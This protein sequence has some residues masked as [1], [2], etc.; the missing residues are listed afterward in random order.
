VSPP[1]RSTGPAAAPCRLCGAETE[2]AL[3]VTD[4]NRGLG[5]DRFEYRLCRSCGVTSMPSVPENLADYY[6]SDGYGSVGDVEVPRLVEG[7]RQKLELLAS[8]AP[9][10][11]MIEI[12][13]G[14]GMFTR[15]AQRS[16]F[17]VTAIEMDD[18]YCR[19]LQARL[20]VR[21]I[22][23][24]APARTLPELESSATIVMWHVIEHLAE[25]WEVLRAC[26]SRLEPG[27]VLALSTPN[28]QSLQFRMLRRH[29]AHLDAP[30]HL[31]L[32]P[33]STLRSG[34]ERLGLRHLRTTTTDQV[35]LDCNRLG[36][37]F[38]LRVNPS[39]HRSNFLTMK[40]SWWLMKAAAPVEHRRLA[41]STYTTVFQLPLA[42]S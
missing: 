19:E 33:H 27:G 11:T 23:S 5:S 41:G 6:A 2:H 7:E 14:P 28:P 42:R 29:W 40:G 22:Q 20:G 25:P 35:G 18:R 4:R 37:E 24:D 30:R 1:P 39:R 15:V 21:A 10:R 38:A 12:G 32:F 13:P 26:V 31:Q 36:W 3:F 9:G 8:H 17:E 16:G 34:L